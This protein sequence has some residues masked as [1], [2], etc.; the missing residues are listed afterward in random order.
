VNHRCG[1]SNSGCAAKALRLR[2]RFRVSRRHVW[3]LRRWYAV[4][5]CSTQPPNVRCPNDSAPSRQIWR[6]G[7]ADWRTWVGH[8]CFSRTTSTLPR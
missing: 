3:I 7:W 8:R 6:R 1:Q 5:I 2:P 4:M